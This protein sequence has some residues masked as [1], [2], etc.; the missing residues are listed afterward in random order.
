MLSNI[1]ETT[2]LQILDITAR[3]IEKMGQHSGITENRHE[4]LMSF[5]TYLRDVIGDKIK[6]PTTGLS[7]NNSLVKLC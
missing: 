6:F 4:E 7:R 5:C 2:S 3:A 1:A